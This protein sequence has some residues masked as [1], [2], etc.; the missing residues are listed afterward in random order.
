MAT[1]IDRLKNA[2]QTWG[3]SKGAR[4][5]VWMDIV[6]DDFVLESVAEK[7]AGLE[8]AGNRTGPASIAG[9]FE[10]LAEAW[11]MESYTIETIFGDGDRIAMFGRCTWTFKATG[12]T[13]TTPI[14][15]LWHF[16]D[17]KAQSCLEIFDSATAAEAVIP[18]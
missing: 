7:P 8:F 17:G 14:A 11:H 12:K 3:D 6:N 10:R 18:D 1:D 16:R 9:Y 13:V 15:H 5:D 2:Y 4:T